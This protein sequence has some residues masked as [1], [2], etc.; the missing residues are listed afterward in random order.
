M[1]KASLVNALGAD[2]RLMG[3][4]KTMLRSTRKVV[5]VTAVRTGSGKSQTTRYVGRILTEAGKKVAVIRHPMP[6]GRLEEQVVQ[7]F[8]TYEDLDL[9]KCTIEER[10]EYEPPIDYGH[11]S[12]RGG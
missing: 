6:Y 5:A 11:G 9:H 3:P 8:A 2:F 10:E 12:L 7:R 1:H 4:N